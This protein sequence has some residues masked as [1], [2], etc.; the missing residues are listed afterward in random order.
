MLEPAQLLEVVSLVT[1][2]PASVGQPVELRF[3]IWASPFKEEFLMSVVQ[4]VIARLLTRPTISAYVIKDF[5][6]KT[7]NL[8]HAI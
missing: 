1:A 4:M 8:G 2:Y 7:V 6:V 3:V 5:S